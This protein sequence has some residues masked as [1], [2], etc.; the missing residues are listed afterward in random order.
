MKKNIIIAVLCVVIGVLLY[1]LLRT[2]TP[3][4]P[5]RTLDRSE[6]LANPPEII[7]APDS[8]DLAIKENKGSET[9]LLETEKY[10]NENV[11]PA[12]EKSAI[13]VE[14]MS[15]ISAVA[16]GEVQVA[17]I[18]LPD[19]TRIKISK[20]E[21]IRF[22]DSF[23]EIVIERDSSG[24]V[25][26]AKYEINTDLYAGS[27]KRNVN[28]FWQKEKPVDI[29]KFSNPNI[30]ITNVENLKKSLKIPK[31]IFQVQANSQVQF[32]FNNP[33]N[34][35]LSAGLNAIFNG[36]GFISPYIGGGKLWDFTGGTNT[37]GVVGANVN[38][39]NFK[40]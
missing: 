3:Q 31:S 25:L 37:Y 2:K 40:K 19:N 34:N 18:T 1:F 24:T 36:D 17:S 39:L 6:T 30:R 32:G 11:Q 16:K 35:Q 21:K 15:K 14:N 27:G 22:K 23:A 20:A 33:N 28:F 29:F 8:T 12:L 5:Q 4:L 9:P 13:S 26:P 7:K 38:I 10:F